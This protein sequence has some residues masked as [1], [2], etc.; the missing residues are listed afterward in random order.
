M[1]GKIH[2]ASNRHA[3]LLCFQAM[4]AAGKDGAIRHVMS[5]DFRLI[6][7]D[8]RFWAMWRE[9][10]ENSFTVTAG[11]FTGSQDHEVNPLHWTRQH[12]LAWVVITVLGAVLRALLGFI[13]SPFFSMMQ[14]WQVSVEWLSHPQSYWLLPSFGFL[15]AGQT[16][17]AA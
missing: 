11:L 5:Y 6:T 14:P 16:F 9:R 10:R 13:R 7:S 2:C 1:S 3:I 4:D 12:Q 8:W 15:I 17:D